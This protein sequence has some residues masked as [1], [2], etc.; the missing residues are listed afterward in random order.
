MRAAQALKASKARGHATALGLS[1]DTGP[2]SS[3]SSSSSAAPQRG[4]IPQIESAPAR[5]VFFQ[6][7]DKKPSTPKES[8]ALANPD[9]RTHRRFAPR[10]SH[11][12][13]LTAGLEKTEFQKVG[14]RLPKLADLDTSPE[15][16]YGVRRYR[17]TPI[18]AD[19]IHS[20]PLTKKGFA[21]YEADQDYQNRNQ[22]YEK[23]E[24]SVRSDIT[25]QILELPSGVPAAQKPLVRLEPLSS[26]AVEG[27]KAELDFRH[28][29][30]RRERQENGRWDEK[31]SCNDVPLMASPVETPRF[32][33]T[34]DLKFPLASVTTVEEPKRFKNKDWSEVPG[35]VWEHVDKFGVPHTAGLPPDRLRKAYDQADEGTQKGGRCLVSVPPPEESKKQFEKDQ[36]RFEALI[37]KLQSASA[38]RL[39]GQP[40]DIK[41]PYWPVQ[42]EKNGQATKDSK[43][44]AKE[45]SIDSGVSGLDVENKTSAKLATSLNPLASEFQFSSHGFGNPTSQMG[46]PL[47]YKEN[48]PFNAACNGVS[49][50]M[51]SDSS[52]RQAAT[53]E[54]IQAILKSM[55]ELKKEITQLKAAPQQATPLQNLTLQKQ[56][57]YM[58]TLADQINR[59]KMHMDQGMNAPTVSA[60]SPPEYGFGHGAYSGTPPYGVYTTSQP[61]CPPTPAVAQPNQCHAYGMYNAGPGYHNGAS[62]NGPGYTAPNYGGAGV[63]GTGFNGPSHGGPSYNGPGFNVQGS[64]MPSYG[65]S[66]NGSGFNVQGSSMPSYGPGGHQSQYPIAPTSGPHSFM[67]P[68]SSGPLPL[69]AQAQIAFGPKPVRKPRNPPRLG[70][71]RFAQQQQD[72]EQYLEIRRATDPE[73]A[74]ECRE[75]Q[76]RRVERQRAARGY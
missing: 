13:P 2:D 22:V 56:M 61:Q 73:F 65:P 9:W 37:G 3:S 50:L 49:P 48:V 74:R 8:E 60:Q 41:P 23:E 58:E 59:G 5:Q 32:Q 43:Q 7:A 64:S 20:A 10:A 30:L 29:S 34:R 63:N 40:I 42:P 46:Y 28:L 76:A 18:D 57:D 26:T 66:Y 36:A 21:P 19:F 14:D 17:T 25:K 44:P 47:G 45:L 72:Y 67:E 68:L 70:D 54:D 27:L 52:G 4:A 35:D 15:S 39:R 11:G 12:V 1:I 16:L 33:N 55:D 6:A 31:W 53:A 62:F 71:R 69:H 51:G 75:R 24:N 38:Y